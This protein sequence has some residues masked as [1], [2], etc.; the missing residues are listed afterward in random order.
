M[1]TNI[2]TGTDSAPERTEVHPAPPSR[3]RRYLAPEWLTAIFTIVLAGATVVLA[4][5]TEALVWSS[6]KQHEDA[7][8][9]IVETKRLAG[10]TEK[11]VTDRE[12]T[13]S[14]E[15][16]MRINAM[17][18][19]PRYRRI[20]DHI[21][22]HNGNYHLPKYPDKADADV[23]EYIGAFEDL[24][25]FIMGELISSKIAYEHFSYEVEKAWCNITVQETIRDERAT[26]KSKTAQSDP[27]YGNFERLAKE[28]L[29]TDG[30]SCNDL[31][32]S[33]VPA[34]QK[35]KTKRSRLSRS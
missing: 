35:K 17:L 10:A 6:I 9:A 3:R 18:D 2:D 34:A 4:A 13:A 16:I 5:A 31:D 11:A 33:P 7:V 32:S 24:G 30:L 22:S 15:F 27:Q 19:Q 12:R 25:Y 23:E 1:D 29:N 21:Q 26:D 8:E 20:T 28:Y 14:A